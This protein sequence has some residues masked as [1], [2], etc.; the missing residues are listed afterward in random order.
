MATIEMKVTL[1]KEPFEILSK[2]FAAYAAVVQAALDELEAH[3]ERGGPI[4]QT[5]LMD[6][7]QRLFVLREMEDE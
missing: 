7:T 5:P 6:A 2:R 1:T 3:L 4:P